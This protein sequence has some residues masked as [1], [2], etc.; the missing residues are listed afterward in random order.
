M[1][2]YRRAERRFP[3]G[4]RSPTPVEALW[5]WNAFTRW[6]RWTAMQNLEANLQDFLERIKSG[7]Y[8]APPVRRA[9]LTQG[10]CVRGRLSWCWNHIY[11]QV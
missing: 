7:R 6:S 9:Y 5:F 1:R 10:G 3:G 8:Q 11:E 2:W 4:I